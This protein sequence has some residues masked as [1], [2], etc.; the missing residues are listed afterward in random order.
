MEDGSLT[1]YSEP[2]QSDQRVGKDVH[3]GEAWSMRYED[4]EAGQTEGKYLVALQRWGLYRSI[5][6]C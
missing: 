2:I 4:R 1:D 6:V 5:F 3:K